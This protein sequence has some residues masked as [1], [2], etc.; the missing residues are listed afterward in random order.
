MSPELRRIDSACRRTILKKATK[1]AL[2]ASNKKIGI[3]LNI[4]CF[5][6][7]YY[8]LETVQK[9]F[10]IRI[11]L[12]AD[13]NNTDPG[14]AKSRGYGYM[15]CRGNQMVGK[16]QNFLPERGIVDVI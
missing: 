5:G 8:S 13:Q 16:L 14:Q 10:W 15:Y 1:L 4:I 11:I 6:K 2:H 12:Y 9:V 3:C 7:P